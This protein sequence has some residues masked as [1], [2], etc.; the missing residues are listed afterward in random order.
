MAASEAYTEAWLAGPNDHQFFTRTYA[1]AAP[2][3]IVIFVHGFVEHIGRYEAAFPVFPSR[4]ITLFAYDQRGFGRTALDAE[5]KSKDASFGKT[6]WA[7]GLADIEWW[8]KYHVEKNPGVP[9]FLMGHSMGGGLVCAFPTRTH[10]PPSPDTVNLLSGVILT[11]PLIQLTHPKPRLLVSA[12]G[13]LGRL[14]PHTQ[15]PAGVNPNALSRNPGRN[16]AYMNDPLVKTYGT[17]RGVGDMLN[18]GERLFATDWAHW[19]K[20]LPVL[21]CHGTADQVT[22]PKGTEHFYNKIPAEDKKLTLFPGAYHEMFQE[23]DNIP[24]K[25]S[26]EIIS[27]VE[28]HLDYD[29]HAG[30]D[31]VF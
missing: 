30:A 8:V 24:E 17:L 14:F 29:G 1:P 28:A 6:S 7:E 10:A 20:N 21:F 15:V 12:G 26:D 31:G 16:D 25:L 9:V 11:S 18:G 5:H 2:R 27:W 3:A 19:P 13:Q 4:G 22:S 23:I